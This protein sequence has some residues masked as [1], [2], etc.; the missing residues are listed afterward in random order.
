MIDD[1]DDDDDDGLQV[2]TIYS[3]RDVHEDE[4]VK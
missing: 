4:Q 1:D 2:Y 3:L